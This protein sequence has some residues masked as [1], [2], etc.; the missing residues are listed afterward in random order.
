MV[1]RDLGEISLAEIDYWFENTVRSKP[2]E[3]RPQ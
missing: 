2:A 3:M 1:V